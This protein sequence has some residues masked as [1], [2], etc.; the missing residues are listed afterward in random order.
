MTSSIGVAR[1]SAS[2]ASISSRARAFP[3]RSAI[4]GPF[5]L[6]TLARRIAPVGALKQAKIRGWCC[7]GANLG[8]GKTRCGR[9][10]ADRNGQSRGRRAMDLRFT[11]EEVAFRDEVRGF[12]ADNLPEDIRER[13]RLGHPAEKAD[14]IRWQRILNARGWAA[15]SW[16]KEWGGP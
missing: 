11:A 12:I 14:T 6:A 8:A 5:P 2:L 15:Y 10:S 4:S 13:M 9:S 1:L 3:G 7:G 16:P